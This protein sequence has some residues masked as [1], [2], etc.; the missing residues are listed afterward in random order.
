MDVIKN[1]NGTVWVFAALLIGMVLIQSGMFL[2]LALKMNKKTNAVSK[3][4]LSQAYKTG[5]VSAIGPAFSTL[6]I[7]LSLIVMV[8]SGVTFMRCGVIGA[9]SY[10]LF[11]A[12]ISAQAAGVEFGSADFTEAIF[13]LCIFGMI[14]ASAPYFINTIITLKPLDMAI[15]KGEK[16]AE[17]GPKKKS[18]IPYLANSAMGGI[19]GCSLLDCFKTVPGGVAFVVAAL[20]MIGISS[21]AKKIK[22]NTLGSFAMDIAMLCAMFVGQLLTNVMA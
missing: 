21:Y 20:V 18:F 14:F 13:T 9:P 10:E 3:E 19:L 22:N 15:L 1:M 16:N 12:N 7:A 2:R 6:T 17:S 4:E 11:I 5:A 8:G